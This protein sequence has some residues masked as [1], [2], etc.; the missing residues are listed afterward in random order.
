MKFK[1]IITKPIIYS[2]VISFI[3]SLAY[4]GFCFYKLNANIKGTKQLYIKTFEDISLANHKTLENYGIFISNNHI[5]CKAIPTFFET[6]SSNKLNN[7]IDKYKTPMELSWSSNECYANALAYSLGNNTYNARLNKI[8]N[9]PQ[10][11]KVSIENNDTINQDVFVYTKGILTKS[12]KI[13]GV[14]TLTVPLS[15]LL[16]HLE[17]IVQPK[18][19]IFESV[20]YSLAYNNFKLKVFNSINYT[21]ILKAVFLFFVTSASLSITLFLIAN[22]VQRKASLKLFQR[23]KRRLNKIFKANKLLQNESSARLDKTQLK[24]RNT[25]VKLRS[26]Q[27]KDKLN[28]E[29]MENTTIGLS[30][31]SEMVNEYFLENK[32]LSPIAYEKSNEIYE[33]IVHILST[34]TISSKH[35][36][37]SIGNIINQII[38]INA[39]HALEKNLTI[40]SKE[41]ND[42]NTPLKADR[43]RVL[44]VLNEALAQMIC[45]TL[46]DSSILIEY[47]S[48]LSSA[49][50]SFQ[51]IGGLLSIPDDDSIFG[52]AK[53]TSHESSYNLINCIKEFEGYRICNS[54]KKG[55]GQNVTIE[56]PQHKK[57]LKNNEEETSPSGNVIYWKNND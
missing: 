9:E 52:Q 1:Y 24:L 33:K 39:S 3:L 57:P 38:E 6:V 29:I 34:K 22:L 48:T 5:S 15:E 35:V 53:S 37:F 17:N 51:E 42:E 47:S 36:T 12:K 18:P 40:R 14:I 26:L 7:P 25:E 54:Y 19:H 49:T 32:F 16:N 21:P 31:V 8:Q 10:L 28:C 43:L 23:Y 2:V 20:S 56:I 4:A 11:F 13:E 46:D 41:A 27:S 45:D 30:Y 50:V 55:E 44:L